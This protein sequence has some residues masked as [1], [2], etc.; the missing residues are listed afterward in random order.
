M[1]T[2]LQAFLDVST[3]WRSVVRFGLRSF[4]LWL[5]EFPLPIG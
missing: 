2:E 4:F 5:K 3:G 1:V